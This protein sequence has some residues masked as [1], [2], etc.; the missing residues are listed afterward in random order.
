ML[1]LRLAASPLNPVLVT[2]ARTRIARLVSQKTAIFERDDGELHRKGAALEPDTRNCALSKL[3]G[4]LRTG[5]SLVPL[6]PAA[7]VLP[8][9]PHRARWRARSCRRCRLPHDQAK[10]V[11][12]G[13]GCSILPF[14]GGADREAAPLEADPVAY[15]ATSSRPELSP[16]TALNEHAARP[17]RT[18][19]RSPVRRMPVLYGSD[20]PAVATSPP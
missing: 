13:Y 15:S 10:T 17:S 12:G 6:R 7:R 11:P 2:Q 3:S 9:R 14:A 18:A 19:Q 5:D 1:D 20:D 4:Q 8:Q 16:Q